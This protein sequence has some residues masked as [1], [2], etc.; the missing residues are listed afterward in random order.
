MFISYS[1]T[2]AD[3]VRRLAE[4]LR[5]AG[6]PTWVDTEGLRYGERWEAVLQEKVDTCSAVVVVMSP[7]AQQS[8]HVG[9]EMGHARRREKPI[10]PILRSGEPFYQL[11]GVLY[12]DARSGRLPDDAFLEQLREL[13]SDSRAAEDPS[14]RTT[15]ALPSAP[16]FAAPR[17]NG[18]FS[19]RTDE[20]D[21]V[22]RAVGDGPMAGSGWRA[23]AFD[24]E[25]GVGKTTLAV[26][27]YHRLSPL[28]GSR[29]FYVDLHSHSAG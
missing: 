4:H 3:Y 23:F 26:H 20:I 22:C 9:N 8:E 29:R 24:G 13:T 21:E 16:G 25:P 7:A 5:Q 27:L 11:D 17:G 19:G 14:I 10:L 2:D 1:R 6:V 28:F 12:F 18:A 15:G